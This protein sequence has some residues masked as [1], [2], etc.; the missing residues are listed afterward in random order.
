MK[1]SLIT[2][3][4]PTP[5]NYRAASALSF[6]LIKY[7]PS[8]VEIEVYSFNSNGVESD[9]ISDIEG[10]LHAKI[11]VIP[12]SKMITWMFKLHLVFLKNFL[13][14]P[15]DY[16][17]T[18][19]HSIVER[20]KVKHP[21]G[22]WFYGDTL[23]F[24]VKQFPEYQRVHSMP[25]C[26]PLYYHRLMGDNFLFHSFCRMLGNCIQYYKNIKMEREYSADKNIHYHLVGEADKQYLM[27]INPNVQ[28]HFIR[29]PHYNVTDKKLIKFSQPKIKILIAGQYN[30][31]M[32]T[33]FDEIL[34]A[35]CKHQELVAY[36]SI[37]FLGKGWD[38]AVAELRN[39]GYESQRL[40]FVDV[41]L[42]EIIKYDVQLTP[43]SVG[44][45]TKGKVLDALANG[46]MVIG[47][48][49]AMENI[50]VEDGKSCIVY[51]NSVQLISVLN[52]IPNNISRYEGIAVSGREA[53][54]KFHD[55]ET[56]S[57]KIF[58]LFNI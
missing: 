7:R 32:K 13:P 34:P 1:I 54:L 36:Y 39:V 23:S 58:D 3:I 8:D 18:L 9:R 42:D 30:L 53:I 57:K 4:T 26:V 41:Y 14:Y 22:I 12:R 29:H 52:D 37:T 46:L 25:D 40:G 16:Y 6:H 45:G 31:Y 33:A 5:D 27:K 11:N 50:A 44:T 56:V 47:T 20:I 15:Y 17:N 10:D 35:L 28:A 43:I 55:R 51:E 24:T 49:Y 38:P 19:S 21:D 48:P 2:N